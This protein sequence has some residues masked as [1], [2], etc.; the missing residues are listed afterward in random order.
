MLGDFA[1]EDR[2]HLVGLSDCAIGVEQVFG[3]FV[4]GGAAAEDQIV[5]E[6][7]LREEQPM[8][9]SRLSALWRGKEWGEAGWLP[10]G[11]ALK[12]APVLRSPLLPASLRT[13]CA[14]AGTTTRFSPSGVLDQEAWI[15]G[16][17]C[18]WSSRRGTVCVGRPRF[19]WRALRTGGHTGS[20]AAPA[21]LSTTN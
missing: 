2:G 18:A 6:L 14:F 12:D 16:A 8:L 15:A 5:A 17:V 19:A 7:D 4:E 13:M 9:A 20:M 11:P 21:G 3:E 1:I 10:P